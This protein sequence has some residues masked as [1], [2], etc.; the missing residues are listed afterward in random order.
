MLGIENRMV[1]IVSNSE[2]RDYIGHLQMGFLGDLCTD[3]NLL[4]GPCQ[5]KK[6]FELM[7]SFTFL[8]L[9]RFFIFLDLLHEKVFLGMGWL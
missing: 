8:S 5:G 2:W 6:N 1:K 9:I 4:I 7:W 3:K